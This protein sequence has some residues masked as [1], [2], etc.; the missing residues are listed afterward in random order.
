MLEGAEDAVVFSTGIAAI[1]GLIL[2]LLRPC[3]HM[4][5]SDVSYAGTAEFTRNFLTEHGIEVS[6]ADMS[7][8]SDV[9]AALRPNT[10][11]VHA[12]TPCNPVLKLVDIEALADLVHNH[13]ARL[14]I[15]GT[16]ATPAITRPLELGA[17]F[18]VH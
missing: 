16:F 10:R 5:V 9:E 13:G 14:I 18:A 3:D 17:D 8:L 7:D 2:Q 4:L 1:S 11:L 15:D 6:V 12:E